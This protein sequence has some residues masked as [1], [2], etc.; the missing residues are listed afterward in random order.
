MARE[1]GGGNTMERTLLPIPRHSCGPKKQLKEEVN[2]RNQKK[3]SEV[4]GYQASLAAGGIERQKKQ[5]KISPH[6][7]CRMRSRKESA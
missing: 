4:R 7:G 3:G 1:M 6:A 5:Y 2:S